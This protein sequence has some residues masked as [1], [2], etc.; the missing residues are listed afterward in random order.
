MAVAAL[1]VVVS[2]P[3]TPAHAQAQQADVRLEVDAGFGGSYIPGRRV[4]VHVT[5][6]AER[7]VRGALEVTIPGQAGVWSTD[8]EVPGG[9]ANDFVVVVPTPTMV[10]LQEVRV[11][12]AGGGAAADAELEPLEDLELVGLLPE[13]TPPDLPEPLVL[14]ADAGTA[15]FVELDV[16]DVAVHGL[17]DPLGTVVAGPEELGR[18]A[19]GARAA[20]L[21]WVDRGGRLVLDATPG[22]PVAGL[23]DD[24]QPGPAGRRAAGLGEVRAVAGAAVAAR[25]AEVVEPTP[26]ASLPELMQL[27]GMPTVQ[28]ESVG[29]SVARDAG[30]QAVDVPWLVAY[31]GA[32]VALA[33]PVAFFA[34]RRRRA[35]GWVVIP[36][37]AGAFAAGAF[38]IGSDLRT[39]TTAAHGSVFESGPAGTRATTVVGLVSRNGRDGVTSFAPGWTAGGVDTSFFGGPQGGSVDVGVRSSATAVEASLPL[40]AGGFGTLRAAG[41]VEPE[42]ALVVGARSEGDAVVGTVTNDLPFAV[43]DVG[44]MVGRATD[45]IGRIGAGETA[46]FRIEGGE[47][48]RRDVYAPPEA[49]LWPGESGYG[50]TFVVDSVVNLGAWNEAHL[51]LGPNARAPGVATVIGWT[52]AVD[53]P[54]EVR[55]EGAPGGRSAFV[56]RT[57]VV[58][59]D[60]AVAPTSSHREL[61]RGPRGME[62]PDDDVDANVEGSLFRLVLP[63]GGGGPL[64]VDIPAY[65]GRLDVWDGAGWFVLDDSLG[66]GGPV[67]GDVSRVRTEVLPPELF[68]AG[69]LWVRAWI[70]TDFG[71]A[72]DGVGLDLRTAT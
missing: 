49:F 48:Q 27:G 54:V 19:A 28:V 14:P 2:G 52:R 68:P 9:G 69:A 8:V 25:W 64:A 33:G 40:A 55:G 32:Y 10:E 39:G 22:A 58:S 21:D 17:L 12:L 38:V 72:F 4:P 43:E 56:T 45:V 26:T 62:L 65:I 71:A 5:V 7:L 47:L 20:V 36:V 42:G 16:D 59:A 23:P 18:L 70:L 50:S 6:R 13:V 53:G 35:L 3:T 41:P 66:G 60:G 46:E 15:R 61:I 51:A 29:T 34:L 44:V 57:P 67:D 11:R 63:Q 37:L 24:W 1:V 30:L 31:L